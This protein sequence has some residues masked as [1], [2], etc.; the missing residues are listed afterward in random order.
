MTQMKLLIYCFIIITPIFLFAFQKYDLS[1]KEFQKGKDSFENGDYRTAIEFLTKSIKQDSLFADAFN[2]RGISYLKLFK[3]DEALKDFTAAI[4]LN[5]LKIGIFGK[6]KEKAEDL[7]ELKK[8]LSNYYFNRAL[9]YQEK[10]DFSNAVSDYKYVIEYDSNHKM[11]Y[12]NLG[13]IFYEQ[14]KFDSAIAYFSDVLRID[15]R[16]NDALYN[17]ANVYI[18]IKD[19]EKAIA[20][21]EILTRNFKNNAEVFTSLGDCYFYQKD[22]KSAIENYSA[23]LKI[24]SKLPVALMNRARAYKALEDYNNAIKD[25]N[26]FLKI[27]KNEP[28]YSTYIE[29]IKIEL[30]Q[31]KYMQKK[32]K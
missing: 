2:L 27:A 4:D 19:Y 23:A 12:F 8:I 16:D 14:K 1:F 5:L 3:Y 31:V 25:Y 18:T 29:T 13:Y 20:D 21:L 11:S 32:K 30:N 7:K 24:T 28:V 10:S 6:N 22:Y 26:N 15:P 9:V 17:R